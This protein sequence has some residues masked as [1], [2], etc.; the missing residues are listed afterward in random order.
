MNRYEAVAEKKR[1]DVDYHDSNILHWL[2]PHDYCNGHVD[3]RLHLSVCSPLRYRRKSFC[4]SFSFAV[5]QVYFYLF[6]SSFKV[7]ESNHDE[8][9]KSTLKLAR[10]IT[11]RKVLDCCAKFQ[12]ILFEIVDLKIPL[13]FF[14]LPSLFIYNDTIY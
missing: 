4:S 10:F 1:I 11:Q 7:V 6:I 3:V 8:V 9:V 13:Y 14:H 2:R 12:N 5:V